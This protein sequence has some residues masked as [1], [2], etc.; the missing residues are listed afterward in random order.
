MK[1]SIVIRKTVEL[2]QTVDI[3]EERYE[4]LNRELYSTDY[5]TRSRAEKE[6][7]LLVDSGEW[8]DE[9]LVSVDDFEAVTET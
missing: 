4:R 6:V 7:D 3:P 9:E 1:V 8:T 2:S 5:A